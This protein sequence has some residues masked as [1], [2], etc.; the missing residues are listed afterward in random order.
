MIEQFTL[1]HIPG[2]KTYIANLLYRNLRLIAEAKATYGENIVAAF[3]GLDY[4]QLLKKVEDLDDIYP[5][6]TIL[7]ENPKVNG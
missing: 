6:L 1:K 3:L 5:H 7:K 4:S 2:E